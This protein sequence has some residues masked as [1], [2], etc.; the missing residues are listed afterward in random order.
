MA[1]T[2]RCQ[3]HGFGRGALSETKGA[4][5]KR[6]ER[7]LYVSVGT[8]HLSL[9]LVVSRSLVDR[10]VLGGLLGSH[11]QVAVGLQRRSKDACD[12]RPSPRL[13]RGDPCET[14]SGQCIPTRSI[15]STI[16][17]TCCIH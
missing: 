13:G 4:K 17:E 2:E 9:S 12:V 11:A 14:T 3:E 1:L 6:E 8:T 15:P 7:D 5:D 16:I 10:S